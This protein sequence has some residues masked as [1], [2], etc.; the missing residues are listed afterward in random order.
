MRIAL[1]DNHGG[2]LPTGERL[3]SRRFHTIG[4]ELGRS[5]GFQT[6]AYLLEA[7]FASCR[8]EYCLRGD[9]LNDVAGRVAVTLV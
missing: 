1:L 3:T 2:R 4:I 6:L 9:F 7:P 5:Y 8:G